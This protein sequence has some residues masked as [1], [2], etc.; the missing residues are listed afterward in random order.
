MLE[1]FLKAVCNDLSSVSTC[2]QP[3]KWMDVW[4]FP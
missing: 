1:Q 4:D 2:I 3:R